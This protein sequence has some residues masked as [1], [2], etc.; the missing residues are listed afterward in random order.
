MAAVSLPYR[1]VALRSDISRQGF[2]DFRPTIHAIR[3][4]GYFFPVDVFAVQSIRSIHGE[5][6]NGGGMISTSDKTASVRRQPGNSSS[7]V[8]I[9]RGHLR[10]NAAYRLF[11]LPYAG[12]GASIFERWSGR[13]SDEAEIMAVQLPGRENRSKE[14]AF[15]DLLTAVKAVASGIS[16]FLE[17]PFAF[18]G[19][20]M[21]ALLAFELAH[22]LRQLGKEPFHLFVSAC[23]APHLPQKSRLHH[24]LPRTQFLKEMRLLN[25]TD[26]ELLDSPEY[27]DM[28]LSF[29]R[30]DLQMID[31]YQYRQRPPLSC[32]ITAFYGTEDRIAEKKDMQEWRRYGNGL[33][34]LC[35][36][37]GDHFFLKSAE[38]I[39]LELISRCSPV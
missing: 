28:L 11:C 30:P 16:P 19:H 10:K 4:C 3:K 18:F 39:V 2:C 34:R 31:E 38:E 7:S 17:E 29:L 26:E 20:S 6:S 5:Q 1:P 36:V 15:T 33:F 37:P 24:A 12:G 9:K 8:W 23:G 22:E 21:G 13:L 25:G 35:V 14:A 32:G 27:V